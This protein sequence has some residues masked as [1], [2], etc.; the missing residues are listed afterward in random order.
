MYEVRFGTPMARDLRGARRR[1]VDG[2]EIK[3]V[4]IGGPL[5]GILP[6]SKL[7]TPFDFDELAAEGC[8][9]GHGGIVAFDDRTDMRALAR[10]LLEFGAHESCGKCFPCR[11]GLQRAF[12]MVDAAAPR[13]PRAARGAARDA[14][15]RLALRPRRRHARADPLP[16]RAL[17]DELGGGRRAGD[18]PTTPRA[19]PRAREDDPGIDEVESTAAVEVEPGATILDAARAAGRY[20]PTLCFDDRHGALRRLPRLHGR[21]GGRRRAGRRVHHAVPRRH[22]GATPRTR[23][24]AAWPPRRRRARALRAARAAR[25]AHRAR[26]RSRASSR[27]ASRAGTGERRT[28]PRTTRAT[29]TWRSSTSCASRAGAACG[30]ATRSRARSRSPRRAA[31]STRGSRRAWTRASCD[32]TCVSCGACADTCPTDAITEHPRRAGRGVH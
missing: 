2:H 18:E 8:M 15:A 14:R 6:G 17:P 21:H 28:A 20:V 22:A 32:S 13:R 25:R 27:S 19:G 16:D 4:Q 10:H 7:D 1:P 26:A 9:V 23:P 31:A 5:G 3:A 29:P 12:E 30:P 24:R 11:I